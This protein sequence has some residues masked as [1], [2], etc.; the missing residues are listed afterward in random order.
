MDRWCI[1]KSTAYSTHCQFGVRSVTRLL[2]LEIV[3]SPKGEVK[4][5]NCGLVPFRARGVDQFSL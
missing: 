2:L 1:S 5:K 3:G 4:K